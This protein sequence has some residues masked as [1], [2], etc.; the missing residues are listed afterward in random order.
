LI[1]YA[2]GSPGIEISAA[3]VCFPHDI[4]KTAAARITTLDTEIFH[5]E[6]WKPILFWGQKVKD[7][8]HEAQK[9][10]AGVSFS[11]LVSAGYF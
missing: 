8:G 6:S 11:S 2:D 9:Y 7:R 10:S 1:T 4:S 3:F 5:N